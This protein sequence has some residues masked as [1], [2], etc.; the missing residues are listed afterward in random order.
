MAPVSGPIR[1]GVLRMCELPDAALAVHGPYM[2]LLEMLF[3]RFGVELL[4]VPVHEGATPASLADADGWLISGSPASVYDDLA[5]IPTAEELVR[6]ALATE[7]PL[8]GICFGHQLVAQALGGRVEKAATGWG[9]GARRYRTVSER[10]PVAG[11]TT[12]LLASH[13]DQVV[14]A[15]PDAEVWSTSDYCPI[16]GLHVGERMWTVQGHPEY[17]PRLVAALYESRRERIGDAAVDAAQ[18]T[19]DAPLS[20]DAFAEAIIRLVDGR[21]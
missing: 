16:A 1:I 17:T 14:A 13:Q 3:E 15:P 10:A 12:T 21:R 18:R 4:D 8:V 19:L 2:R 20:N 9:I 7:T 6:D 11:S 5:W